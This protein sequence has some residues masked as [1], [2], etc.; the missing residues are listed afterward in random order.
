M[1]VAAMTSFTVTVRR[2]PKGAR[3][4]TARAASSRARGAAIAGVRGACNPRPRM[5]ASE[6]RREGAAHAALRAV[7]SSR[8]SAS[9][10]RPSRRRRARRA[11]CS[12]RTRTPSTR[13]PS[14]APTCRFPEL[15]LVES[16]RS[17]TSRRARRAGAR[18]CSRASVA[19]P[20]SRRSVSAVRARWPSFT[21][22]AAPRPSDGAARSSARTT[23]PTKGRAASGSTETAFARRGS[24]STIAC[25]AVGAQHWLALNQLLTATERALTR[26][27][28]VAL[29]VGG[30]ALL[31]RARRSRRTRAGARSTAR[32]DEGDVRGA[33]GAWHGREEEYF[34]ACAGLVAPLAWKDVVAIPLGGAEVAA[35]AEA[36]RASRARLDAR[37][38]RR[39]P[40]R[41]G[42]ARAPP[43]GRRRAPPRLLGHRR[44]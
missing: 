9:S 32:S 23:S 14:A 25:G 34:R 42:A 27:C 29:G 22:G 18:R 16:A 2:A 40:A 21:R 24:A 41:A 19:A 10:R 6:D 11:R 8:P 31:K 17:S 3:R 13:A 5:G 1:R 28:A 38:I 36:A 12:R 15:S 35:F 39:A 26:H 37:D 20:P 33:L 4:W 43:Q 30:E 44:D 7:D